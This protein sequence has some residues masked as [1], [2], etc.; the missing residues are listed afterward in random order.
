MKRL[1]LVVF[2]RLPGF[3]RRRLV[4]LGSPT[5]LVGSVCVIEH[6]GAVLLCRHSYQ[7]GWGLPGGGLHRG[8][9]PLAAAV[10]E[11]GEEVNLAVE[12]V[13]RPDLVVDTRS[14]RV[15]VVY[16]CRLAPGSSAADARPSS[17][18][19]VEV[20]WVGVDSLGGHRTTRHAAAAL[21]EVGLN[22]GSPPAAPSG[23]RGGGAS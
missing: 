12:P 16:R 23:R 2:G 14:R 13:D 19:I 22:P 21:R 17:P 4:R 18:E 7:R 10:R 8:E 9:V 3:V 6:D 11:V 20:A 1:L 5:F 15:D